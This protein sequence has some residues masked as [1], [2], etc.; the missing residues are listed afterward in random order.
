MDETI[1]LPPR[2]PPP[3]SPAMPVRPGGYLRRHWRGELPLTQ[4][5]WVNG[6]LISVLFGAVNTGIQLAI[7]TSTDISLD[8][9]V[10]AEWLLLPLLLLLRLWQFV[11]L[12]RVSLRGDGAWYVATRIFTVLG[13][14]LTAYVLMVSMHLLGQTMQAAH[15]QQHWNNYAVSVSADGRSIETHGYIGVG[16]ASTV[17]EALRAH[18]TILRLHLDSLGGDIGNAERLAVYIQNQSQFET[19]VDGECASAC[20]RIFVAGRTRL[21]GPDGRLDFH[22]A[23]ALIPNQMSAYMVGHYKLVFS[24]AMA[25]DGASQEFIRKAFEKS[26]N[27][28]Y[29]PTIDELFSN[30]IVTGLLA[31][32]HVYA[33]AEWNQQKYRYHINHDRC[34]SEYAVLLDGVDKRWPSISH[35]LESTMLAAETEDDA[36]SRLAR[37]R[38]ACSGAV[39]MLA[40]VSY[41]RASDAQ[42]RSYAQDQRQ[43]AILLRDKVSPMACGQHATGKSFML[44]DAAADY[45]ALLDHGVGQLTQGIDAHVPRL[46]IGPDA[47]AEL[48]G[49]QAAVKTQLPLVIPPRP[50]NAD[51]GRAQGQPDLWGLLCGRDIATL[52]DL[53]KLPVSPL[54]SAALRGHFIERSGGRLQAMSK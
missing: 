50:Q 26:G 14:L 15:E 9:A 36:G 7:G 16:F 21:L 47:V 20:T 11:G 52:D 38:T 46:R 22:Q 17:I 18:P 29:R 25:L 43:I 23:R 48:Q 41:L 4:S 8:V 32:G 51:Q 6:V 19:L 33:S 35:S 10:V 5:F 37:E 27:E 44:G 24:S 39:S 54:S 3:L 2:M 12:W 28:F 31:D 1:K 49:V 45:F 53:L 13:G 34:P 40:Y 30:G 42:L